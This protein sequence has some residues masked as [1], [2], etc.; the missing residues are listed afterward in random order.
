MKVYLT[1]MSVLFATSALVLLVAALGQA[2]QRQVRRAAIYLLLT[3]LSCAVAA[4]F[5]FFRR[6]L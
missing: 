1:I 3:L 6:A 5:L 4:G 2:A